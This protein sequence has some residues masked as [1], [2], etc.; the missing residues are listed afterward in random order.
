MRVCRLRGATAASGP[1]Q[2]WVVARASLTRAE[3]AKLAALRRTAA[4]PSAPV[5]GC[6]ARRDANRFCGNSKPP[7]ARGLIRRLEPPLSSIW[8]WA[9]GGDFRLTPVLH[10]CSVRRIDRCEE[11][12]H[13]P[14]ALTFSRKM[15]SSV[16]ASFAM[17][18]SD[19]V[20]STRHCA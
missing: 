12:H 6:R 19:G 9:A 2:R 7:R 5:E 16:I 14:R 20:F 15:P 17:M 3:R 4:Q 1:G 18:R 11:D 13:W 8:R 10:S